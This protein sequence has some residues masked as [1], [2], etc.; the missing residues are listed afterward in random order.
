[1]IAWG[2]NVIARVILVKPAHSPESLMQSVLMRL[3]FSYCRLLLGSWLFLAG[4]A[5]LFVPNAAQTER[6]ARWRQRQL[7][8]IAAEQHAEW[9]EKQDETDSRSQAYIHL[10]GVLLGGLGFAMAL[11]ETAYA[12]GRYCR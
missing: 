8:K 11:R 12:T 3:I 5:L 9:I 7:L 4:L 10:T 2:L 1:L 6:N